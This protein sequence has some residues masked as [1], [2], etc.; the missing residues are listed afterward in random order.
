MRLKARTPV[1]MTIP[2]FDGWTGI[3]RSGAGERD[4]YVGTD[5]YT[6]QLVPTRVSGRRKVS[7]IW[8]TRDEFEVT[9]AAWPRV[10]WGWFGWTCWTLGA[11]PGVAVA[12]WSGLDP[13]AIAAAVLVWWPLGAAAAAVVIACVAALVGVDYRRSGQRVNAGHPAFRPPE[14]AP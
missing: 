1:R 2:L 3:T 10:R 6:I 7:T 13:S 8:A 11:I 5:W 9:G 4:G 12:L 14:D